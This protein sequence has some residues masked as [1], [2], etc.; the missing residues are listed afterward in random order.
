MNY[1]SNL[2]SILF[3][4]YNQILILKGW[5]RN[6]FSF[7]GKYFVIITGL[8]LT[9][10]LYS[11]YFQNRLQS[12][13]SLN[14]IS[15]AIAAFIGTLL[16][17]TFSLSVIP[18]QRATETFSPTVAR[19]YM[20]D[21]KIQSIFILLSLIT[22]ISFLFSIE[23]L[24]KISK[25]LLLPIQFFFLSASLELMRIYHKYTSELLSPQFALNLLNHLAKKQI[26]LL[27]KKIFTIS[28]IRRLSLNR[29]QKEAMPNE[30]LQFSLYKNYPNHSIP[31][32]HKINE[33]TEIAIKALTRNEYNTTV[34][35]ISKLKDI[36]FCYT[37][38]RK[39]NLFIY[40]SA[41]YLFMVQQ[42][43]IDEFL[44]PIYDKFYDINKIALNINAENIT[45]T[46]IKEFS[47]IAIYFINFNSQFIKKRNSLFVSSPLYYIK[48]ITVAAERKGS[49]DSGLNGS[50]YLINVGLNSPSSSDI[51]DIILPVI[52]NWIDIALEM[53]V[54]RNGF[55]I[56]TV[57]KHLMALANDIVEKKR[58][59]Y[60]IIL[61]KIFEANKEIFALG[62]AL[63]VTSNASFLNT[64]LAYPFD[65]TQEYSISH[66]IEKSKIYINEKSEDHRKDPFYDFKEINDIIWHHIR[67]LAEKHDLSNTPLQLFLIQ[68]IKKIFLSYISLLSSTTCINISYLENIILQIGWYQSFFWVAFTNSDKISSHNANESCN[69]ITWIGLN[70]IKLG[71]KNPVLIIAKSRKII[72]QSINNLKTIIEHFFN[73]GDYRSQHQ[74]A[75][76]LIH[77]E[78]LRFAG[79]HYNWKDIIDQ[80]AICEKELSALFE[81]MDGAIQEAYNVRKKQLQED[82][83]EKEKRILRPGKS[84][85]I[86]K[87]ILKDNPN[88][89]DKASN[90]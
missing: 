64:P 8:I 37:T 65:T 27:E 16:I 81:K 88:K 80:I 78:Q 14:T 30:L 10:S 90:K 79:K 55:F 85:N 20:Q 25:E 26:I 36:L 87:E 39:D 59:D 70:L 43:D 29:N 45:I 50:R 7:L 35:A 6:L 33:I 54:I 53:L 76:L 28:K 52:D 75:N 24:F 15:I 48:E 72:L 12:L 68:T 2:Y 44:N 11:S 9:I 63:K 46:I 66:L 4:F 77:F 73:K 84:L 23:N 21:N 22:L 82:L 67:D 40:P 60:R 74:I 1:Q 32:K 57:L 56:N 34:F 3:F 83:Q 86:L 49:F 41:E 31:I 17:L 62:Y 89:T 71:Q 18:I 13:E 58:N 38:S 61:E 42:S 19:N 5:G 51:V 69:V 47:N